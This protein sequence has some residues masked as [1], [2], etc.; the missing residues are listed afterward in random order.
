MTERVD[1]MDLLKKGRGKWGDGDTHEA[2]TE[3][4]AEEI[5]RFKPRASDEQLKEIANRPVD[6]KWLNSPKKV[7]DMITNYFAK[8]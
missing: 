6:D 1:I 8:K 2:K 4:T 3:F 5:E 7:E